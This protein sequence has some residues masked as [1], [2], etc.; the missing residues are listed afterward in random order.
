MKQIPVAIAAVAA[1]ALMGCGPAAEPAATEPA[2]APAAGE[3]AAPAPG[4]A[5]APTEALLSKDGVMF[6]NPTGRGT[7]FTATFGQAQAD[8][9]DS[10]NIFLGAPG[11]VS[12][13]SECGAGPITFAEW[14]NGFQL[15]FQ[16]GKFAGWAARDDA[17]KGFTTETGIGIGSTVAQLREAHPGVQI[18]EDSLGPE[19]AVDDVY[20]LASATGPTGTVTH[21]WAGVSCQFR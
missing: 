1:L 18:T 16:E 3:P 15:L 10:L 20:G 8:V 4:A 21:L 11:A 17:P 12:T 7:G 19:F 13:N 9:I 6:P 5:Y 14:G 2:A